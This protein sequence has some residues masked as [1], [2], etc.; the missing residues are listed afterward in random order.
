[1][2]APLGDNQAGFLGAVRDVEGMAL[3]NVGTG[4]QVSAW[5]P[6][7]PAGGKAHG[8]GLEARPFPGGG[9]LLVGATLCA[10]RA[11][12]LLEEF[13]RSVLEAFGAGAET[14]LYDRMNEL[15][16]RPVDP[17]VEG[18]G[19]DTRFNGTREDPHVSGAIQGI[20][21]RNLTPAALA[22]GFLAG[23][24]EELHG[25]YEALTRLRGAPVRDLAASGNGLRRNPALQRQIA[26]RFGLALRLPRLREEAAL[27]AALAAAVGLG[28]YPGFRAAGAIISYEG[29]EAGP[30]A[31]TGFGAA[32]A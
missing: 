30:R 17:D 23:I 29:E 2:F 25:C 15:A 6:S 28:R 13:F 14:P 11:Y 3:L 4:G 19:V 32:S 10:G 21:L 8:S 22:C 9:L 18:L 26:R 20:N 1:V 16:S 5:L 12:A 27:G 24:A 31:R 7:L